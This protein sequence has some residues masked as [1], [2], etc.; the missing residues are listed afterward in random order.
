MPFEFNVKVPCADV[1]P[2]TTVADKV[3]PEV[4]ASFVKTLP[5]TLAVPLVLPIKIA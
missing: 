5:E 1:G 2:V 3:P 4:L